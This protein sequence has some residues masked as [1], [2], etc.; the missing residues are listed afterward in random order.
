M[1]SNNNHNLGK[2][3]YQIQVFGGQPLGNGEYAMKRKVKNWYKDCQNCNY[4]RFLYSEVIS[5]WKPNS[6][7]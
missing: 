7:Q 4:Y 2:K 3:Y 1:C 5:Q 6:R